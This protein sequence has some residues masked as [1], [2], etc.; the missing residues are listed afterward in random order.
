MQF[1]LAGTTPGLI[2][3][4]YWQ[5]KVSAVSL[6]PDRLR[7]RKSSIVKSAAAH[8]LGAQSLMRRAAR[9]K[10]QL[11]IFGFVA[12]AACLNMSRGLPL[13]RP[14]PHPE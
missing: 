9:N 5:G 4:S 13:T 8:M 7:H 12:G 1:N 10:R 11:V 3:K 6:A 14:R 2:D